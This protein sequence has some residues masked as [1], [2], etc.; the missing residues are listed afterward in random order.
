MICILKSRCVFVVNQY[1]DNR[2]ELV[3]AAFK[4]MESNLE[5]LLVIAEQA[6]SCNAM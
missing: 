3:K 4:T 6:M 1:G 2:I 5:K